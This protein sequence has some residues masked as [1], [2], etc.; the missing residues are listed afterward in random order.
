MVYLS[1]IYTKSGDTGDTSLGDGSRVR[2][3][4]PRVVA[5]GTVDELNAVLGLL[6]AHDPANVEAELLRSIQND[7]FDVGADLCV[8]AAAAEQ[9]GQRLRVKPEQSTRLEKEIDRLN[10]RLSPRSTR[11]GLATALATVCRGLSASAG[12]WNT[13]WIRR[14]WSSERER[15]DPA[16]S[17]PS[18]AIRPA[19]GTCSP[20]M[21][22]PTV[23]LPL[24]DSPT[25]ATQRPDSIAN[26]TPLTAGRALRPER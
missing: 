12:F 8:P 18:N 23:V 10:A 25:S 3:D 22:R 24:P 14:R 13:I 11:A 5:Y 19:V 16:S 21:Q 7:L 17:A 6:L 2:K 26:E 1:R 4:H 15:D 20:A 9:P